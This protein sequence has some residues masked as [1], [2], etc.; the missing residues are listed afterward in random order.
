MSSNNTTGKGFATVHI[1]GAM[2]TTSSRD[3][4]N[5]SDVIGGYEVDFSSLAPIF[6]AEHFDLRK[7]CF[8]PVVSSAFGSNPVTHLKV[9]IGL[10]SSHR[11]WMNVRASLI[12]HD[13]RTKGTSIAFAG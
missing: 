7:Q 2:T 5:N 1:S 8:R 6:P 4:H 9:Q 3:N 13:N 10:S 12:S 11:R